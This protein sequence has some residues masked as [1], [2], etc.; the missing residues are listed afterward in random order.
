MRGG[1]T[2]A[3]VRLM[4]EKAANQWMREERRGDRRGGAEGEGRFLNASFCFT[5]W[6]VYSQVPLHKYTEVPGGRGR[7]RRTAKERRAKAARWW[8]NL[9][10][11]MMMMFTMKL[12]AMITRSTI[13]DHTCWPDRLQR[14]LPHSV[15]LNWDFRE[16]WISIAGVPNRNSRRNPE[17]TLR[18]KGLGC[19]SFWWKDEEWALQL[20]C[21][22]H[23]TLGILLICY[24]I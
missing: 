12:T 14:I 1:I 16:G 23:Q 11:M 22:K 15:M 8:S 2:E 13:D 9:I 4:Q 3:E 5:C 7:K 20:P 18:P 24:V 19:H 17:N 21:W 10:A 6:W